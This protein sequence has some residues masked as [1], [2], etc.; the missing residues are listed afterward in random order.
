[1]AGVGGVGAAAGGD[2]W[3]R[4]ADGVAV[5]V[6][7]GVFAAGWTWSLRRWPRGTV[8]IVPALWVALEWIRAQALS[9]FPWASLGYSQYLNRPLIQ[10]ADVASVYGVSFALVLGNVVMAQLLSAA[11]Q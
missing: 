4:V 8:L 9:G 1:M 7:V 11:A 5:G 10:V 2:A 3:G 6:Y